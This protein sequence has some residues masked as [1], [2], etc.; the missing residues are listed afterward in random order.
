MD[1]PDVELVVV[2]GIP[3]TMSQLYQVWTIVMMV[4]C[5]VYECLQLC[6]RA[7]RNV[8]CQARA[9]LLLTTDTDK[10]TDRALK[11]FCTDKENCLRSSMIKSLGGTVPQSTLCCMVCN[12]L[13]FSDGE[14][15]SVL[16]AGNAP[17]RKKRRVAVRR[18][19]KSLLDTVMSR[20]KE[21]RT[22]Y[23]KEHPALSILGAQLVCPDSVIND[24]CSSAKFI[25]A[26]SDMDWFGLRQELKQRFFYVIMSTVNPS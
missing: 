7:G 5:S 10:I 11:S 14:R 23:I 13:A 26:A 18:M 1:I 9:H 8:G 22:N 3:D 17:P 4:L 21:E 12:P 19:D 6:G 15:L 25:C 2:Y 20:L 16:Q 24:I